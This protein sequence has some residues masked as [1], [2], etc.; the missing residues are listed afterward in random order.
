MMIQD[1]P[2]DIDDH[3]VSQYA[4][5]AGDWHSN[6]EPRSASLLK[7]A[8]TAHSSSLAALLDIITPACLSHYI[9]ESLRSPSLVIIAPTIA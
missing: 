1:A 9:S 5:I 8:F 7:I 3:K 2:Y 6:I 4:G